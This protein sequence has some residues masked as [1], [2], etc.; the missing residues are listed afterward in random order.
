MR[1]FPSFNDQYKW[2]CNKAVS[3]NRT[4]NDACSYKYEYEI[5]YGKDKGKRLLELY[6]N[7]VG[8]KNVVF[9]QER[10]FPLL[11]AGICLPKNMDEMRD[12]RKNRDGIQEKR[13]IDGDCKDD[14]SIDTWYDS[15]CS[16]ISSSY[17]E[18][19]YVKEN[20]YSI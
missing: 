17:C 1:N 16:S 14:E 5:I 19:Q 15:D 11:Q 13:E 12:G 6:Q 10:P 4:S 7:N 3:Y 20:T 2:Y 9:T 18:K 8:T